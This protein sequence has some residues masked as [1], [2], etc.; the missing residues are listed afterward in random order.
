M[1]GDSRSAGTSHK[2][3]TPKYKKSISIRPHSTLLKC[4]TTS[5]SSTSRAEGKQ[6]SQKRMNKKSPDFIH[7]TGESVKKIRSRVVFRVQ[8]RA[9]AE[10]TLIHRLK[11]FFFCSP[12]R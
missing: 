2:T 6:P 9:S 8:E 7:A 10:R 1:R 5:S 4:R 12:V 11:S 3:E